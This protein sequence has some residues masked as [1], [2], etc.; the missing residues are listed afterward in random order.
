MNHKN[1]DVW[2]KS[3]SLIKKVYKLAGCLPDSEKFGLTNQMKRAA[4]SITSNVA[5]GAARESD[6]EFIQFLYYSLG[7]AAELETQ[8]IISQELG[9]LSIPNEVNE[10]LQT[11]QRKILGLIRYLKSKN[12]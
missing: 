5:E 12:K 1:L 9:F 2:K 10:D 7:S 6:K 4:V 3:I 11:T 8:L